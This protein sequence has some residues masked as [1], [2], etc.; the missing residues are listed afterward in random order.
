MESS[1]SNLNN[2]IRFWAIL[3]PFLILLIFSVYLIKQSPS[4][5]PLI[6]IA[7]GGLIGCWL[8]RMKGLLLSLG[9]IAGMLWFNFSQVQVGERFWFLGLAMAAALSF[10][11]TVLSYEEI[12]SLLEGIFFRFQRNRDKID[13]VTA[14]HR[15]IVIEKEKLIVDLEWQ[16]DHVKDFESRQKEAEAR[17]A[18]LESVIQTQGKE[19]ED[20]ERVINQLR[21]EADIIPTLHHELQEAKRLAEKYQ[22]KPESKPEANN[23]YENL[24]QQLR[25]QFS[26]KGKVLDQ[27]RKELFEAQEKVACLSKDMEEMVT[28]S[29]GD[30]SLQLEKDFVT[31]IRELESQNQ[32]YE[33]EIAQL[34]E[35]VETLLQRN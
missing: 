16:K 29:G 14:K 34:Q 24:Y 22:V 27:T 15:Q 23:H 7:L 32:M 35:L 10:V 3:G 21:S 26:E 13:E 12:E 11:V 25:R 17:V 8:W 18:S 28:Y 30:C 9:L 6:V 33:E 2:A 20:K 31:M 5:L 4:H 1:K 19:L